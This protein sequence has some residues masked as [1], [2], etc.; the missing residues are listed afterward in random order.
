VSAVA[1]APHVYWIASRAAGTAAL[2][3][4]SA[5]VGVGV[6]M[7]GRLLRGRGPDQRVAHEALSL[8]TM[9][10]LVVHGATLLGDAFMHPSVADV[11]IPFASSY[12]T[13]WTTLGIV[14]AWALVLL[15][16]SYYLRTR[17]GTQRWKNLHRWTLL[18]WVLG[19]AHALGEGTDAGV[20]WFMA[21]VAIVVLPALLLVGMRYH[22]AHR[23][24]PAG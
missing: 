14:A 13:L 3:L 24:V 16:L 9:V 2:L 4:S 15:G 11:T 1:T 5:A 19:L 21:S 22:A 7:G 18:A 12:K 8:A 23:V 10:A 20:P 6:T 17:I